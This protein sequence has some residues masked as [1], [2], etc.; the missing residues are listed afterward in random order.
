[1]NRLKCRYYFYLTDTGWQ[2]YCYL[3]KV[4]GLTKAELVRT[5]ET[6][7]VLRPLLGLRGL[8]SDVS[9]PNVGG[10]KNGGTTGFSVSHV[11]ECAG[12]ES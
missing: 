8:T 9:K 4:V 6:G 3:K 2:D 7:A 10:G 1:M 12:L 11:L 5:G